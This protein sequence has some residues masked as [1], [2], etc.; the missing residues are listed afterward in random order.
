MF[1]SKS[2]EL[3]TSRQLLLL[4]FCIS[5]GSVVTHLRFG[6]KYDMNLAANLLLIPTVNF[7]L[8]RPTFLKSYERISYGTFL[9]PTVVSYALDLVIYALDPVNHALHLV[10]LRGAG[11]FP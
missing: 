2:T 5:Q 11:S 6:E 3:N 9:W 1:R 10:A 4:I 7:F 8:N